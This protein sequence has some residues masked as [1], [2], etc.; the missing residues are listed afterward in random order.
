MNRRAQTLNGLFK[1]GLMFSFSVG[2]VHYHTLK[3]DIITFLIFLFIWHTILFIQQHFKYCPSN[4]KTR[5]QHYVKWKQQ[6]FRC[7]KR[8]Y[9]WLYRFSSFS[10]VMNDR[11]IC[12]VSCQSIRNK[13]RGA[14]KGPSQANLQVFFLIGT[15]T[16]ILSLKLKRSGKINIRHSFG[17][18]LDPNRSQTS[19]MSEYRILFT[20]LRG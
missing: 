14:S 17:P 7:T 18:E 11:F 16:M 8:R 20:S 15:S 3:S 9:G 4:K 13:C 5:T 2:K 6:G 1:H 19:S 10:R 12:T